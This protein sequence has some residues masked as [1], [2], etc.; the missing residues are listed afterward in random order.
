MKWPANGYLRGPNRSG[1]LARHENRRKCFGP[2]FTPEQTIPSQVRDLRRYAVE[3]GWPIAL[4]V[5]EVGSGASQQQMRERLLEA[6]LRREID[7]VLVWA[8]GSVGAIRRGLGASRRGLR[9]HDR[10]PGPDHAGRKGDGRSIGLVCRV[11]T[12]DPARTGAH[13]LGACP[14]ER[15]ATGPAADG[16]TRNW[17]SPCKL[18][19][20]FTDAKRWRLNP[21]QQVGK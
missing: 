14:A 15:R 17:A 21:P 4:Q 13:R 6:A 1:F 9:L 10:S 2:A 7:V 19:Y 18:S 11:R 20:S 8:H 5:K 12:R 3:R 16:A